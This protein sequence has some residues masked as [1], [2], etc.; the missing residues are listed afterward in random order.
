MLKEIVTKIAE[1][2]FLLNRDKAFKHSKYIVIA[3]I[4]QTEK[5]VTQQWEGKITT[6]KNFIFEATGRVDDHLH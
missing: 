3:K 1:N 2:D 4:E 5:S 6:L